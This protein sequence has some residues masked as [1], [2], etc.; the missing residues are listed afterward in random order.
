MPPTSFTEGQHDWAFLV[1][2]APG[3][4]SRENLTILQSGSE[5]AVEAGR[6]LGRVRGAVAAP[7]AGTAANGGRDNTGNGTFLA[8]PAAL[9]GCKEGVYRLVVLEPGTDVGTFALF[10]PDGVLVGTGVVATAYAGPHLSFT[11]QDGSTD[12]ASGDQFFITVAEGTTYSEFD[13]DNSNGTEIAAAILGQNV[14]VPAA[15]NVVASCLVREAEVNKG[16]LKWPASGTTTDEIN[17]AL[18]SLQAR[19]GIVAR[20]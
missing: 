6:V 15:A 8:T 14:T 9:A 19:T 16:E 4:R 7:V 17:A 5:R 20:T 10:D 12:F 3:T 13:E 11:L 1:S 2:E 18:A